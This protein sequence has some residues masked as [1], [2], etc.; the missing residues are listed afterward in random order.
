MCE[1]APRLYSGK[2]TCGKNAATDAS[3][4]HAHTSSGRSPR[5][6]DHY[7]AELYD[8]NAMTLHTSAFAVVCSLAGFVDKTR[9]FM[10]VLNVPGLN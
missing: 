5:Y 4:I 6:T 2:N 8:G 3:K 1:L 10:N 7:P 9:I